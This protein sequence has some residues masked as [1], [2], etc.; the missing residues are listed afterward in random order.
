MR[1]KAKKNAL[2]EERIIQIET[3]NRI[4]LDKMSHIWRVSIMNIIFSRRMDMGM[5]L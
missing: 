4:L 2:V 1:S 5:Y 3:E